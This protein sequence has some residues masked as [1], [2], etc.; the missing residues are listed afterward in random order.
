MDAWI[1]YLLIILGV[2]LLGVAAYG[3]YE[4][5]ENKTGGEMMMDIEKYKM[6]ILIGGIVLLGIGMFIMFSANNKGGRTEMP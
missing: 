5:K 2:I 3:Y 1:S 4:Q 6:W